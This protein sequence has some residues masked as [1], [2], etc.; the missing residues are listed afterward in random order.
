M[1]MG[2][3]PSL[4]VCPHCHTVYNYS[5]VRAA[6]FKKKKE[7][8]HCKK[9]FYISRKRLLLLAAV[10]VIAIAAANFVCIAFIKGLSFLALTAVNFIL[11]LFGVL[12]VPFYIGFIKE[13]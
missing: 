12:A 2:F 4:P 6:A 1:K 7:C 8:Y 9:E 3:L 10:I 13:R 11:I 5:E